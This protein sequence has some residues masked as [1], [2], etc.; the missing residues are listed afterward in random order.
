METPPP[1]EKQKVPD[2]L[3]FGSAMKKLIELDLE[4]SNANQ[5]HD[6]KLPTPES[7]P[8]S[9]DK[10]TETFQE[11]VSKIQHGLDL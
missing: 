5:S 11:L 1:E 2:E 6:I 8:G 3:Q 9:T 7:S 4:I 10:P